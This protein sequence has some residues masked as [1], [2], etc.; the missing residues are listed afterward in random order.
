MKK[1]MAVFAV[2]VAIAFLGVTLA[3]ASQCP[4]LIKQLK[5]ASGKITDAKKKA[6]VDKLIAEAQKLHDT[7][8]HADSVKKAD[9]AAK[10]AGVKLEKKM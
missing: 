5:D 10:V 2:V 9:E 6:E 4:L 7:G 3:E 1:V 8:K